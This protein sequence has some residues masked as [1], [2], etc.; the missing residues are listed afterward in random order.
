MKGKKVGVS[1]ASEITGED[2]SN[3][4]QQKPNYVRSG[5][6]QCELRHRTKKSR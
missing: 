2:Y 1:Q 6:I 5:P 4:R 3:E